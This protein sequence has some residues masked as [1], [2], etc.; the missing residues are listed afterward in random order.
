MTS[1]N[2]VLQAKG[3][4]RIKAV[5]HD[6]SGACRTSASSPKSPPVSNQRP[7]ARGKSILLILVVTVGALLG[8]YG[9]AAGAE[10]A[11]GEEPVKSLNFEEG[12][13]IAITQS[14]YFTKSSLEIEVKRLDESDSRYGLIP[15][16]SFRTRYYITR[17]AIQNVN[18]FSSGP[19]TVV[20]SQGLV[21]PRSYSLNFYS[22][23]YNPFEAYF[24]LQAR[25][26][27]TKIAI[28][29]HMQLISG[30]IQRLGKMFLDLETVKRLADYQRE[31]VDLDRQNLEYF[32]N[33]ASI[34]TATSLEVKVAAQEL[35]VAKTEQERIKFSQ[36]RTLDNLK[37][38]LGIKQGEL[39]PDLRDVR[40]QVLGNFDAN[41]ATLE[42]AR[43]RS[44]ELKINDI[45]K[46]LQEYHITVAKTR[47]LPVFFGGVQSPDPLSLTSSRDMF[48]YLGVQVPVWDGLKRYRDISRQKVLLK[49]FG[50]E[51]ES[52]ELDLRDKWM[53]AL[54]D[55]RSA[56]AA[57][58]LAQSQEDLARLKERQ[59]EIRYTSGT[60]PLPVLIDGRKGVLDAKK[61]VALKSLDYY[62]AILALRQLSGDLGY[63]YVDQSS[64][65]N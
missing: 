2:G 19:N 61:N 20:V 12:V 25:K 49:E 5:S 48:F 60:E 34:G 59:A 53:S 37:A 38:F 52:K 42:Q 32:Q 18:V 14:P 35:E 27:M 65:Q 63:R 40:R 55:I 47:L 46:K 43:T 29:S 39:S 30:G 16:I 64:W 8:F 44:W 22:D 3:A 23:N 13:R 21:E 1:G 9:S 54:E 62:G 31:I 28:L 17:P 24:S 26:L 7:L 11:P 45:K 4:M 36:N 41:A 50:S 51:T 15:A 10:A 33:R 6:P 57:Q 58:Q 56:A